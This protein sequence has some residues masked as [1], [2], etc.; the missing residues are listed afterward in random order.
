MILKLHSTGPEVSSLQALLTAAGFYKDAIDGDFGPMTEA[1]VVKFQQSIDLLTV[2]GQVQ[3]AG[4]GEEDG[5]TIVMLRALAPKPSTPAKT[6][7]VGQKAFDLIVAQ[8]VVNEF[9]YAANASHPV[10][11]GGSSGVTIGIGY[12][13]GE[14]SDAAILRDWLPSLGSE[15]ATALSKCTGLTG[16][17]AET[18]LRF[19]RHLDVPWAAAMTV[20][21]GSTLPLYAGQTW[22]AMPNCAEIPPDASGALVS[23]GY[24][25]GNGGWRS[26]EVEYREMSRIRDLMSTRSYDTIPEQILAMRRLWPENSDLW[27]RRSAEAELFQSAMKENK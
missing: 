25:R 15:S 22:E 13:C 7:V 2:D 3:I 1:A 16:V 5:Q 26:D 19:V 9:W 24:N 23:I 11:P 4:P 14:H 6:P 21:R 17:H 12:D 8:E 18:A 10:W 27:K 20:F